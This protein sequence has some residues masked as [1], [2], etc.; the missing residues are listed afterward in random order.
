MR[1]TYSVKLGSTCQVGPFQQFPTLGR[2]KRPGESEGMICSTWFLAE[3]WE[4]AAAALLPPLP[5]SF[6]L[7]LRFC[8]ADVQELVSM[9]EKSMQ[10]Q[11]RP[12]HW[13]GFG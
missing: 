13:R 11:S 4:A 7:F 1:P 9:A 8:D 12:P 10:P 2:G 6:S 3:L 5:S